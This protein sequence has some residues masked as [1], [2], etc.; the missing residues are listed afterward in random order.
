MSKGRLSVVGVRR[1]GEVPGSLTSPPLSSPPPTLKTC[2]TCF[3]SPCPI[4][5]VSA[6][7]LILIRVVTRKEK[8]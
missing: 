4:A 6:Q 1:E 7:G 2:K 5:C 3:L 8:G